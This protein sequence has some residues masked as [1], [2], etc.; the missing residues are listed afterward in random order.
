MGVSTWRRGIYLCGSVH[1]KPLAHFMWLRGIVT[2]VTAPH[3][4]RKKSERHLRVQGAMG[5]WG[6]GGGGGEG[7]TQWRIMIWELARELD[8]LVS[9]PEQLLQLR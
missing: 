2:R 5:E 9:K 3:E 4:L 7:L 8:C 6:G 1:A